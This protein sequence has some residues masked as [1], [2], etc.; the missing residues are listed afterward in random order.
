MKEQA[1]LDSILMK[2]KED[3]EAAIALSIAAA[4]CLLFSSFPPHSLLCFSFL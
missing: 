1:E 2:E 3:L 4:V